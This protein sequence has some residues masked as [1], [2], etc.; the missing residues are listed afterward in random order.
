MPSIAKQK[1][2]PHT[3][4]HT[5]AV[6][7]LRATGDIDAAAK[8]LGHSSLN[9]TKIYTD[10][11]RSRLAETVNK[12]SAAVLGNDAA[13]WMPPDDLLGWLESL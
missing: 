11:D 12:M 6:A 9:T 1:I 13:D 4:R 5:T 7:L 2:S 10:R 8:I 3:I